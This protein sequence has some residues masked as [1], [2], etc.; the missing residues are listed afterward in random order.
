ML[1]QNSVD[2]KCFASEFESKSRLYFNEHHF[3]KLFHSHLSILD[4][5]FDCDT[6]FF[7]QLY[8]HPKFASFFTFFYHFLNSLA[9]INHLYST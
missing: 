2:C 6:P 1:S 8:K 9:H 3:F 5:L 4:S 7:H